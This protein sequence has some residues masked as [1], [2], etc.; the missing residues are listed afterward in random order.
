METRKRLAELA[1][2]VGV[3]ISPTRWVRISADVEKL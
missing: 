1:V 3:N 2:V